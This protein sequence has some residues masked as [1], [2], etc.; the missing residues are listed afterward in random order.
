MGRCPVIVLMIS[1]PAIIRPLKAFGPLHV[2]SSVFVA[3]VIIVPAPVSMVSIPS[4]WSSCAPTGALDPASAARFLMPAMWVMVKG[5]NMLTF[6]PN[7]I[8]LWF[9]TSVMSFF[10][11]R[12]PNKGW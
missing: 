3:A 7:S 1:R 6:L 4:L 2:L 8:S 12:M 5:W 10:P 11:L 9:T